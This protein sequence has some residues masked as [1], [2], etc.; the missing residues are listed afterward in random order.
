MCEEK[1]VTSE[2]LQIKLEN[3]CQLLYQTRG[4]EPRNDVYDETISQVIRELKNIYE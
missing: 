3:I 4:I 2:E 1:I